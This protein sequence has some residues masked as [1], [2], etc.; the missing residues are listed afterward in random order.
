MDNHTSELDLEKVG[1]VLEVGSADSDLASA[2]FGRGSEGE[3]R[4]G[5]DGED[6]GLHS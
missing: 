3:E 5:E 6:G 2:S 1:G 4:E